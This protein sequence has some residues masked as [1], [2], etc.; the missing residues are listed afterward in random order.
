MRKRLKWEVDKEGT[1]EQEIDDDVLSR[2]WTELD[3]RWD[4][5][6]FA[7]EAQST[8]ETLDVLS[9]VTCFT[10]LFSVKLEL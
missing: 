1:V 3:N 2:V 8:Y 6:R 10:F 9:F 4:I 7:G 5:C